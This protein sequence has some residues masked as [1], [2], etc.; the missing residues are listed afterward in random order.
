[1]NFSFD[2]F[3]KIS[4]PSSVSYLKPWNI[5]ENV[6]F[7]GVSDPVSGNKSDGTTW[8]AWDFTFECKEG[9]YSER[10]F[11]PTTTASP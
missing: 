1:M 4:E 10:I 2:G 7:K 3:S 8:K 11:E 5:Y 9:V 6:T